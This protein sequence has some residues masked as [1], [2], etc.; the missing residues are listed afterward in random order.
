[1]TYPND[2]TPI[3]PV[4][5]RQYRDAHRETGTKD[6]L[7]QTARVLF[8]NQGVAATP[9][10]AVARAAHVSRTLLYYY[11]SSKDELVEAVLNDYAEDFVDSISLWNES[12][13][14]GHTPQELA[15]FSKTL[16]RTL[17][18]ADGAE[19]P[20]VRMLDELGCRDEFMTRV[21]REAVSCISD[22]VVS[23]YAAYHS[24]EIRL[25]PEM[26]CVVLAGIARLYKVKPD[27]S[28]EDV[29]AIIAQTLRLDMR[30]I[31]EPEWRESRDD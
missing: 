19:R 4:V 27:I 2:E 25:V 29:S 9:L 16:R 21:L 8:E 17:Y 14:F 6:T 3:V 11:F 15:N 30:V 10:A 20:I 31:D 18:D 23:E 12:R 1:M 7:V 24:I 28:D 5:A 26:F 22:Q 13:V